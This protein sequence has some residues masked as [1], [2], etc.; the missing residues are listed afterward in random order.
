MEAIEQR[1]TP[2]SAQ[3]NINTVVHLEEG[4]F[5]NERWPTRLLM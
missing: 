1:A 5:E 4:L 2:P 3:A